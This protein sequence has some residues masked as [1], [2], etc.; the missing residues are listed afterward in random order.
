MRSSPH[1]SEYL[2]G[3]RS[4][5]AAY[6]EEFQRALVCLVR[7]VSGDVLPEPTASAE[8][9]FGGPG[10]EPVEEEVSIQADPPKAQIIDLM[11]ALEASLAQDRRVKGG[12]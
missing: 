8:E 3:H 2:D 9:A 4:I 7:E 1:T 5:A 6:R 11:K 12:S 10:E